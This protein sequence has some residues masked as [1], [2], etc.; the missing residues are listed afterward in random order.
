MNSKNSH[1]GTLKEVFK[2]FLILGL[3][4]F[5]GPIAHLGYFHNELVIRRRWLSEKSYAE[6]VAMCQIL[7]GPASSQVGFALGLQRGGAAGALI[8]WV[9]FTLPSAILLILFAQGAA[10]FDGP[11]GSAMVHGLKIVAVAVVA[12]AA[13]GMAIKLCPDR[14]RVTI[15]VCSALIIV[16]FGGTAAQLT[17]IMVGS[18]AGLYWCQTDNV[19]PADP[20]EFPVSRTFALGSFV[21]FLLLLIGLPLLSS[22]LNI[23]ALAV[24]DAFYRSGSLVFGGGHVVLPL[25]EAE[26]VQTGWLSS[27]I[28]LSGYGAAQAI[29]GPLFTFSAYLGTL[30]EAE[31]NGL[32]GAALALF[33]VFLPGFLLLVAAIPFWNT[34]QRNRRAR[35]MVSGTNAAVVGILA[36]ALYNPVG[37]NAIFNPLDFAL[38]LTGF[39]LLAKW[40]LAPWKVVLSI[41]LVSTLT[42]IEPFLSLRLG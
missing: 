38:A 17:S 26:I 42:Q 19:Q 6:L 22:V 34:L 24:A 11:F 33:A 41:G 28:F 35:A 10:S 7:P 5:G 39:L 14:Q 23:Q 18:L 36:S 27:D 37:T 21:L 20:F 29:P 25:L 15:A 12:H 4:S 31:P 3:T 1:R 32:A 16:T 13:W 2:T 30:L 9:A 40:Q 8:A